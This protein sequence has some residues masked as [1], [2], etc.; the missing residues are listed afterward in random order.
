MRK[1][2]TIEVG[3]NKKPISI[4]E[5]WKEIKMFSCFCYRLPR[6][7]HTADPFVGMGL[8][9]S[10]KKAGNIWNNLLGKK[11]N[12]DQG[13]KKLFFCRVNFF[14]RV[15]TLPPQP[16]KKKGYTSIAVRPGR[17]AATHAHTHTHRQKRGEGIEHGG[18][19]LNC[20]R[21]EKNSISPAFT[22][23]HRCT[24]CYKQEKAHI[25]PHFHDLF[26]VPFVFSC[27]F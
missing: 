11:I 6:R 19:K 21:E 1:N 20:P 13:G 18:G 10:A 22:F 16:H 8:T 12:S 24:N 4:R 5:R 3:E 23:F 15:I 17:P 27:F 25:S 14:P 7:H 26:G 2:W 9:A